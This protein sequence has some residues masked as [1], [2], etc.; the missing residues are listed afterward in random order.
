MMAHTATSCSCLPASLP[1]PIPRKIAQNFSSNF[2]T[3]HSLE[4]MSLKMGGPVFYL[5][6]VFIWIPREMVARNLAWDDLD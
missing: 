6:L 1:G 5:K 4:S 2:T 3:I